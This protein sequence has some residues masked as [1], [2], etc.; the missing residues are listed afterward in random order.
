MDKT[1]G[2]EQYMLTM[3][4]WLVSQGHEVHYI[5]GET[6]R[7]DLTHL[8]SMTRN[9]RVRFNGNWV[10][11]PLPASF[12]RIRRLLA[13]EQFDI[14]YIQ[15]PYS[16]FLAGRVIK[17]VGPGTAVVGI[18]H[19]APYSQV[20]VWGARLLRLFVARSLKRFDLFLSVSKPAQAFARQAFGIASKILPN[21]SPLRPFLKARAFPE[22]DKVRTVIFVGRLVERKGCRYLLGA[23]AHLKSAGTWPTDAQVI[24]CGAGPLQPEL[25][26]FV[27]DHELDEVVRFMGYVSEEDKPRFMASADVVAYPSLGGESFG[28]VLLE[29]MAAAR[30]AV[31]A[32]N[33]PGYASVMAPRPESLFD[34][35]DEPALAEK[36]RMLLTNTKT[37]AAA[38]AWQQEYVRQ[39]DVAAV[40]KRLLTHFEEALHKRRP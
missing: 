28:I 30:G 37:R 27:S 38:H 11:V 10:S 24:I 15:M 36:I 2:V 8:H 34:P 3:G 31:L 26:Q 17:C 39:F 5:V 40:G 20:V 7:T 12:R 14:L 1:D 13:R 9:V 25:Q 29:A 23:I 4:W 32:G 6:R 22:Y 16:P 19:I 33:N 35:R 21:A 18:Y